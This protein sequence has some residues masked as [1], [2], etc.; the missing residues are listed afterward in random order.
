M[1]T[2]RN[3]RAVL[4]DT[5]AD[6]YEAPGGTTAIV[7]HCQI[8]NRDEANREVSLWWT[9]ASDGDAETYLLDTVVVPEDASLSGVAGKLVLEAGDRLR[10]VQDEDDDEV[11]VS[12]S[13]LEL[14]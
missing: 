10:A 11:E 14:T 8:T 5:A 9:D 2:F 12:V 1:A 4:G 6:V 13:V 3:S 7:L